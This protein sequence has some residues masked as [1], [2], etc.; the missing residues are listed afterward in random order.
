MTG[1]ADVSLSRLHEIVKDRE[2]W[3]AAAHGRLQTVRHDLATERTY[4]QPCPPDFLS[5]RHDALGT[6][7]SRR[8]ERQ[9]RGRQQEWR[10]SQSGLCLLC[11][12]VGLGQPSRAG[13]ARRAPYCSDLGTQR[14]VPVKA[15]DS[16]FFLAAGTEAG[17]WGSV[18]SALHWTHGEKCGGNAAPQKNSGIG[19]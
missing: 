5:F 6:P 19:P 4:T 10:Q 7:S 16:L 2:A 3:C 9:Q 18:S 15:A 8:E 17:G 14:P 1:S 11:T 13:R 12:H